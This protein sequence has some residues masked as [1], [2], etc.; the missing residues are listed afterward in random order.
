MYL[1]SW[2][3]SSAR[4][5]S[6]GQVGHPAFL[7]ARIS[8]S[9]AP[10]RQGRG[11][12]NRCPHKRRGWVIE[13]CAHRGVA[14]RLLQPPLSRRQKTCGRSLSPSGLSHSFRSLWCPGGW[15]TGNQVS[16]IARSCLSVRADLLLPRAI[17]RRTRS[18]GG[19]GLAENKPRGGVKGREATYPPFLGNTRFSCAGVAR[20]CALKGGGGEG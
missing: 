6:R 19:P 14:D 18:R 17:F 16:N 10:R 11:S 20:A 13:T 7:E 8:S 5:A 4:R 15:P 2:G 3:P 9:G 1:S 12:S